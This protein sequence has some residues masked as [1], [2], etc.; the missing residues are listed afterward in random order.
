[1]SRLDEGLIMAHLQ[2]LSIFLLR[3]KVRIQWEKKKEEMD[4][5]Q[6]INRAFPPAH[7]RKP[8]TGSVG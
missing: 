4:I 3:K 7:P 1:M 6:A 8:T 2:K 5:E